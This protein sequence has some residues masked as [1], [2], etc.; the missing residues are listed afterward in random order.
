MS[1]RLF[2]SSALLLI[3]VTSLTASEVRVWGSTNTA[4]ISAAGVA[5]IYTVPTGLN[6]VTQVAVTGSTIAALR[7]N[8]S[9][10]VWGLAGDPTL[11]VPV[12]AQSGV[13]QIA[14]TLFGAVYALR[15]DG[16]VIAWGYSDGQQLAVPSGLTGVVAVRGGGTQG[17]AIKT[18]GSVI[19]WGSNYVAPSVG[20]I[21]AD[22]F[23][24]G[25]ARKSD[26]SL[27]HWDLTT[28]NATSLNSPTGLTGA[29][30][31]SDGAGLAGVVNSSGQVTV[32]GDT[33]AGQTT[34]PAGL[35]GI[36]ELAFGG[37]DHVVARS[38]TGNLTIWG[39]GLTARPEIAV[40]IGWTGCQKIAAGYRFTVGVFA[41]APNG[42][43]PTAVTLSSTAVPYQAAGGLV[44]G[45]LGAT[46]ADPGD[47]P[48][49]AL[50]TG[51][52]SS[53]NAAFSISGSQLTVGTS[54]LAAPA[55]STVSVRIRATDSGGLTVYSVFALTIGPAPVTADESTNNG[56][57][58]GCGVGSGV[59][60]VL[61]S[62]AF[63]LR[64]LWKRHS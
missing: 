22:A 17:L 44:I 53:D 39:N 46:D 7:A 1:F 30:L 50:V 3:A 43:A 56:F 61:G 19:G 25:V 5:Q 54:P 60:I 11:T 9:V 57:F 40:P 20:F 49:F 18:D 48:T 27:V 32:W 24:N 4:D 2:A 55:N 26:S 37:G 64:F 52:G 42:S 13:T 21:C 38:T 29:A 51:N 31:F 23:P 35:T 58:G 59:S 41:T 10:I 63:T 33:T 62:L 6:D 34:V 45:T 36:A 14:A 47:R 16:T 12:G 8:G 15:S 28:V